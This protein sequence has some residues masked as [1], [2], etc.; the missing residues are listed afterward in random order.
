M[1]NSRKSIEIIV[2]V[3]HLNAVARCVGCVM[4]NGAYQKTHKHKLQ[5]LAR[6]FHKLCK[7][8]ICYQK[9]QIA[10]HI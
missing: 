7:C 8:E 10:N 1:G 6:L 4:L 5:K 2:R 3:K 9:T